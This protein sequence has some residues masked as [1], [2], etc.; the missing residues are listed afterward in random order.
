MSLFIGNVSHEV[1]PQEFA[2]VF[3]EYGPCKIKL[4]GSFGFVDYDEEEA[5]DKAMEK[6]KGSFIGGRKINIEYS[7]KSS[8][9]V[10]TKKDGSPPRRNRSGSFNNREGWRFK[11]RRNSRSRSISSGRRKYKRGNSRDRSDSRRRNGDRRRRM[12]VSSRSNSY[13]RRNFS[14]RSNSR[15][16]FNDDKRGDFRDRRERGER[17][18]RND[19]N[20]RNYDRKNDRER[21]DRD[22]NERDRSR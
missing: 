9:F 5:G 8:K 16:R 6:L 21:Y 15:E 18:E 13:R 1:T 2:K 19:R 7:K 17:M 14:R 3:E 11:P 22:R 10:P 12:S 20:D 4:K